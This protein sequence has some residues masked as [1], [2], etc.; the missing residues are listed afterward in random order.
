MEN[1]NA[2]LEI[3]I[4]GRFVENA[5]LAVSRLWVDCVQL[6]FIRETNCEY[7]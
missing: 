4:C 6:D 2:Y 7:D 3:F 5:V 1:S